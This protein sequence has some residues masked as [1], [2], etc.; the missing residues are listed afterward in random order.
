M[1][2]HRATS[3]DRIVLVKNEEPYHECISLVGNKH[4]GTVLSPFIIEGN[5]NRLTDSTAF[6]RNLVFG[7]DCIFVLGDENHVDDTVVAAT[8]C[9]TPC[10]S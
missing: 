4:S 5:N 8:G 9:G 2:L 1:T 10:P 6:C 3:G 7:N